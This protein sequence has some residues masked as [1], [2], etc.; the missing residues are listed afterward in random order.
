MPI[1]APTDPKQTLGTTYEVGTNT[2]P[3]GTHHHHTPPDPSAGDVLNGLLNGYVYPD[4]A[5]STPGTEHLNRYS[6]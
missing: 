2:D 4:K 3:V 5:G 1:H 6:I